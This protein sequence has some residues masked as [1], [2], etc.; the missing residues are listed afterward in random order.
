MKVLIGYDYTVYMDCMDLDA[1]CPKKVVTE[2]LTLI[3]Q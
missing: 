2:I 3:K 1:R